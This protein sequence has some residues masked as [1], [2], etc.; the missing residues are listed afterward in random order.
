MRAT[1]ARWHFLDRKHQSGVKHAYDRSS[2][3]QQAPPP[4]RT[5][6]LL[7]TDPPTPT[8]SVWENL[9]CIRRILE[10]MSLLQRQKPS[11]RM[12]PLFAHNEV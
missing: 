9:P 11:V 4:P 7:P 5:H 12:P 1:I 3:V 2:V 6:N 10:L 8:T